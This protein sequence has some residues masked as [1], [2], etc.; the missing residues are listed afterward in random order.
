[1]TNNNNKWRESELGDAV[2][3][4][5]TAGVSRGRHNSLEIIV[6]N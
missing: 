5:S 2:A 6:V 4:F 1:M 3:G